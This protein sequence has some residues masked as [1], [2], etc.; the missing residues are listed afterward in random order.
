MMGSLQSPLFDMNGVCGRTARA[1]AAAR[2]EAFDVVLRE[3]GE[4]P[5]EPFDEDRDY[6]EYADGS[7]ASKVHGFLHACRIAPSEA[8][9]RTD[10]ISR[11]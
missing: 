6:Q 11:R 1:H 3:R 5:F 2:K 7:R 8:W 4:A 9:T 10:P